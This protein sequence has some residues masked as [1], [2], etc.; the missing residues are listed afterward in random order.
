MRISPHAAD[1][2]A[3]KGPSILARISHPPGAHA[4]LCA[5]Q[6]KAI[7][8]YIIY[9]NTHTHLQ[10]SAIVM[11]VGRAKLCVRTGNVRQETHKRWCIENPHP[12]RVIVS[13]I[14]V[15][16]MQ[17]VSHRNFGPEIQTLK[18]NFHTDELLWR[19]L[20]HYKFT[21]YTHSPAVM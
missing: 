10:V 13:M 1:A 20:E 7:P 18:D 12:H 17:S 16:A 9:Y 4:Q 14:N 5:N 15:H 3:K 21:H 2:I 19:I 6:D 8:M 11:C